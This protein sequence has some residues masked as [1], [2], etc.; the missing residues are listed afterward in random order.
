MY[1]G[2]DHGGTWVLVP[3]AQLP[4]EGLKEECSKEDQEIDQEVHTNHQTVRVLQ[5]AGWQGK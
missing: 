2:M 1:C 5:A 3:P 4:P